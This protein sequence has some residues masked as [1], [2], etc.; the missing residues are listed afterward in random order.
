MEGIH[1][2]KKN[3][4]LHTSKKFSMIGNK[5]VSNFRIKLDI[6]FLPFQYELQEPWNQDQPLSAIKIVNLP[7]ILDPEAAESLSHNLYIGAFRIYLIQ[8]FY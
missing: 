6:S 5:M 8:P 1:L 2:L 4:A 7:N 3:L